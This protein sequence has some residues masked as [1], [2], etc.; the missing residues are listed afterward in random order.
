MDQPGGPSHAPLLTQGV[1]H[2]STKGNENAFRPDIAF[3][4]VLSVVYFEK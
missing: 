2:P 3:H 1:A 4:C